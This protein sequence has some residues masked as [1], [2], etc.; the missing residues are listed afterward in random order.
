MIL[1]LTL[2]QSTHNVLRESS[3]TQINPNQ[4]HFIL[5]NP[6][7]QTDKKFGQTK[8]VYQMNSQTLIKLSQMVFI[9]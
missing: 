4:H 3:L 9:I 6:P 7:F 8:I 5:K 2:K 1:L